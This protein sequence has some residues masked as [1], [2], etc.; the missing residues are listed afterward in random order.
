M[1]NTTLQKSSSKFPI[2][3]V[4]MSERQI[5]TIFLYIFGAS[6]IYVTI[7]LLLFI[8][9]RTDIG[10]FD[11]VNNNV[12]LS[13][14]VASFIGTFGLAISAPITNK[15]LIASTVFLVLTIFAAFSFL[16]LSSVVI[17]LLAAS[18]AVWILCSIGISIMGLFH[19]NGH[20][21]MF[22]VLQVLWSI[23]CLV[24]FALAVEVSASC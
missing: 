17:A 2:P 16:V 3:Q 22:V 11:F 19:K 7:F 21:W 20:Y 9:K 10:V 5:L 14:F 24:S 6:L 23:F 13:M 18:G 15:L 4:K 1:P 8:S 12:S